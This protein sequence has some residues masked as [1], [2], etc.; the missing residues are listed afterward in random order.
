MKSE[1]KGLFKDISKKHIT[2]KMVLAL[3]KSWT[4][5]VEDSISKIPH[6]KK[7]PIIP[8]QSSYIFQPDFVFEHEDKKIVIEIKERKI[9][10]SDLTLIKGIVSGSTLGTIFISPE[11]PEEKTYNL[12]NES[13]I[14]IITGSP[15]KVVIDLKGAIEE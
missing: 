15:K 9:E 4:S 5:E 8:N 13:G 11:E 14:R 1:S 2:G 3:M 10:P 7:Q 12:A 6:I